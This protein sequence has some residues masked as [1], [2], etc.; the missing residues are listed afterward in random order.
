MH[1]HIN[2]NEL[3]IMLLADKYANW[4]QAA[5]F[6]IAGHYANLDWRE[7]TS[8]VIDI[9]EIRCEWSEYENILE[10]W[11]EYNGETYVAPSDDQDPDI[12]EA[13]ETEAYAQLLALGAHHLFTFRAQETLLPGIVVESNY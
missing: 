1:I 4:S 8:T 10:W 5:A 7:M 2:H 11:A 13:D 9:V 3:T 6:A 12:I